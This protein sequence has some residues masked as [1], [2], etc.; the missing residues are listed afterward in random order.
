MGSAKVGVEGVTA[1]K[2][3]PRGSS[4]SRRVY[5]SCQYAENTWSVTMNISE[6]VKRPSSK[7]QD[8]DDH[9]Y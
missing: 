2:S 4:I 5:W 6:D 7:R 9:N 8:L 1:W 3:D